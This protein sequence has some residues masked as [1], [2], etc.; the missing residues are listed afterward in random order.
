MARNSYKIVFHRAKEEQ[1]LENYD[2][3]FEK[4]PN[5]LRWILLPVILVLT[6]IIFAFIG[7]YI[8]SIL[9]NGDVSLD[10][11]LGRIMQIVGTIGISLF[12]SYLVIPKRKM[13]ITGIISTI[14]FI[15]YSFNLFLVFIMGSNDLISNVV[16]IICPIALL[17]IS[18]FLFRSSK[19]DEEA[20]KSNHDERID[21]QN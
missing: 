7:P 9:T 14:F 11:L 17:I 2:W 21:K 4:L 3:I 8:I 6:F 15:L 20:E 10:S 1:E 13:L 12:L 16:S 5:W 19:A 18:I